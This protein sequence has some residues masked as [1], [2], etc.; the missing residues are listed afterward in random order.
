[1]KKLFL[2][3]FLFGAVRVAFGQAFDP[4]CYRPRIGIEIDT[5]T[6]PP[7]FGYD[8]FKLDDDSLGNEQLSFYDGKNNEVGQT[9]FSSG[10]ITDI[11]KLKVIKKWNIDLSGAIFGHFRSTRIKDAFVLHTALPKIYW[12]DENG[13]FD[14]NRF[15]LLQSTVVGNAYDTNKKIRGFRF[16]GVTSKPYVADVT[17]DGIDDIIFLGTTDW[18]GNFQFIKDSTRVFLLFYNGAKFY[19]LAGQTAFCD[20]IIKYG[21]YDEDTLTS[22]PL[23]RNYTSGDF[24]GMGRKDLISIDYYGN[25]FFFRNDPPFSMQK[26]VEGIR[27]DTLSGVWQNPSWEQNQKFYSVSRRSLRAFPKP[28]WDKS[29]DFV[30]RF[31]TSDYRSQSWLFFRGG[32]NFGSQRITLDSAEFVLRSPVQLGAFNDFFS[33]GYTMIEAG[34]MTGTGNPV[35]VTGGAYGHDQGEVMYYVLGKAIDEQIDINI[36]YL[37]Y[38][39]IRIRADGDNLQ[40]ILFQVHNYE[41]TSLDPVSG[42]LAVLHGTDKIPVT[43]NPKYAV[44]ERK[45]LSASN[46]NLPATPNPFIQKTVLTF[47]NCSNGVMYME[48]VNSLGKVMLREEIVNVD[49]LQQYS[50]DLSMLVPG[51]YHIRLVCPAEG[52]S[53]T[54]NVVKM[55]W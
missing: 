32:P 48:V 40:D 1:M 31:N 34:D 5:V 15:T 46:N 28:S 54:A 49:G 26:F 38:S 44:V 22:I 43:L 41:G 10:K 27:Y 14:S 35:V 29:E 20:S 45:A 3:I 50:A 55:G 4:N 9:I 52:W 13:D 7:F 12:S 53:A 39:P 18:N 42:S 37:G 23:T 16:E 33:L 8:L 25:F 30:G 24:R 36:T 2:A 47:D 11:H 6:G 51:A 21:H 19:P 17:E